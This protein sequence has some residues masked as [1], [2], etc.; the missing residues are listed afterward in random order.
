MEKTTTENCIG[1]FSA[2]QYDRKNTQ[3]TQ[4]RHYHFHFFL[5]CF[6]SFFLS[7]ITEFWLCFLSYWR[8]SPPFSLARFN[9][10]RVEKRRTS[11]RSVW[12]TA[13]CRGRYEEY[14]E[15]KKQQT[16]KLKGQTH[17]STNR[18]IFFFLFRYSS[19]WWSSFFFPP[20]LRWKNKT[21]T[22]WATFSFRFR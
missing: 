9:G 14:T 13:Q 15:T 18:R 6:R 11:E 17:S 7:L 16:N 8:F 22:K 19:L 1:W 10:R 12:P 20:F 4:N 3:N 5:F 2:K 21:K